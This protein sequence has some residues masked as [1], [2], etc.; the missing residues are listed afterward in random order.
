LISTQVAADV[1]EVLSEEKRAVEALGGLYVVG[2]ERH[3]SVRVD[4]QLRGR[5]GRQG[6]AGASRFFVSVKDP[7]FVNFGGERI[8]D[9]MKTFRVGD[10][11]PVEAKTVTD[12]LSKIQRKVEDFNAE[13]RTNV[14][15]FDDVQDGQRRALY[16]TRRRLLLADGDEASSTFTRW[17]ADSI[18]ATARSVDREKVDDPD[19][20]L[21]T[22]LGQFFG[23]APAL[24]ASASK[25]LRD[26]D[27]DALAA[28]PA[29]A[30]LAGDI[31]ERVGVARPMRP[32]AESFTKVALLRLDA[33]WAEHL[34]NMNSLKE[35]V[36]LR[37]LQQT[38][39][40]Q[41]YQREGYDLFQALQTRVRADAVFS[42]V[43]MARG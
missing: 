39:P 2:T 34:L 10:D 32:A 33:L 30:A 11:L 41:E 1:S 38:D 28:A 29:V 42:M 23:K 31:L 5:S 24:D 6:D 19:A 4:D 13:Q 8:A 26:G 27:A 9:M 7:M 3:E 17:V 40:F 21:A 22:R 35:N 14:L 12:A 37:T 43:Q 15:K 25:A 18:I 36:Q 20:L 16:A